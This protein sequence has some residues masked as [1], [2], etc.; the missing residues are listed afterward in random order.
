MVLS[1]P[2]IGDEQRAERG[3]AA[4]QEEELDAEA[5]VGRQKAVK[6]RRT[7]ERQQRPHSSASGCNQPVIPDSSCLATASTPHQ[8]PQPW[9][10]SVEYRAVAVR[11]HRRDANQ[12]E[13]MDGR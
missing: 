2:G 12:D 3:K 1:L 4:R 13:L 8:Q 10:K 7:D 6:V 11:I 5:T 9:S